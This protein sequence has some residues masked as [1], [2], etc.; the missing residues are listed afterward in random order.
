MAKNIKIKRSLNEPHIPYIADNKLDHAMFELRKSQI[1]LLNHKR[2][3]IISILINIILGV[4][5]WNQ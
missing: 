4:Y 3:L 1:N 2:Y 5:L